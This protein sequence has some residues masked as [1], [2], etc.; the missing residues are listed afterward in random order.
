MRSPIQTLGALAE[1]RDRQQSHDERALGLEARRRA[2]ED[3]AAIRQSLQDAGG[4][5]DEAINTL[6]RSGR[7]T[8]AGALAKQLFEWRKSQADQLKERLTLFGERLRFSTQILQGVAG[9]SDFQS[10]RRAI[11]ALGPNDDEW[12][13]IVRQLGNTYDP[14]VVKRAVAWGTNR[15]D[16]LRAQQDAIENANKAWDL[17]LRQSSNL[18]EWQEAN[19]KAR[20]HYTKAASAM[21]STATSQPQWAGMRNLLTQGGTP[22]DVLAQFGDQWSAAAVERARR[23]GMTPKEAADVAHQRVQERQRDRELNIRQENME[24]ARGRGEGLTA[25]RRSEIAEYKRRQYEKLENDIQERMVYDRNGDSTIPNELKPEI[26]KRKLE[27]EDSAREMLGLPPLLDTEYEASREPKRSADLKKIRDIYRS[28]TGED[29]PLARMEA[30]TA[31]IRSEGNAQKRT[32]LTRQL[33]RLRE[34]YRT[35]TGR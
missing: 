23:L 5:P 35:L 7:A 20:E 24:G 8:A 6:Y 2:L 13:G 17:L 29:T 31:K 15:T 33:Q 22:A 10:A 19:L 26:A 16:H 14:D 28:L 30:L 34:E 18:R 25:N 21:L 1:L 9:D 27:I 3:D 12:Q 11:S 32:S 4:S